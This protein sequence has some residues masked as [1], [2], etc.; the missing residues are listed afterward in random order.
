[1][2]FTGITFLLYF[3]PICILGYYIFAFSKPLQ[4]FWLFLMSLVLYAWG[5][6]LFAIIMA[7]S[8]LINWIMGLL[9]HASGSKKGLKKFLLAITCIMDVSLLVVSKYTNFIVDTVY[10]IIAW[11]P[12]LDIPQIA[13]SIG[14]SVFVLQEISYIVDVYRDE[15]K[16]QKNPL[17]LGLYISFFP[18]IFMGPIVKYNSFVSQL[19]D[20]K[21]TGSCLQRDA[22]DFL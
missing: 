18:Q 12:L 8:V 17:Y 7:G 16:V 10:D 20:R 9:I 13:I 19:K 14:A 5:E 6:P 21:I 4:N 1:M 3:L 11:E 15:T 22:E 2:E